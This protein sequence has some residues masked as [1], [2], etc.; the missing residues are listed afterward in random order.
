MQLQKNL[1]TD[2][3]TNGI[4]NRQ[5]A[6]STYF[7]IKSHTCSSCENKSTKVNKKK[8]KKYNILMEINR[9]ITLFATTCTLNSELKLF[10][11]VKLFI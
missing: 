10:L 2:T 11:P 9:K 7:D 5:V 8:E 1:K 6:Y 3:K 4:Q